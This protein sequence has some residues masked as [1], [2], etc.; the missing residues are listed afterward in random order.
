[1]EVSVR[2]EVDRKKTIPVRAGGVSKA[3]NGEIWLGKKL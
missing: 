3:G 2:H 1:M